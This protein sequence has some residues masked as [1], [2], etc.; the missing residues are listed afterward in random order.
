M[1]KNYAADAVKCDAEGRTTHTL[2]YS[3]TAVLADGR[4]Q[5]SHEYRCSECG[6][7]IRKEDLQE[8]TQYA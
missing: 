3:G 5:R 8:E 7:F 2:V 6:E 1:G 4:K